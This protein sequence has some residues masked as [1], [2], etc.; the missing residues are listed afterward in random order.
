[1]RVLARKVEEYFLKLLESLKV[2]SQ[3]PT[4]LLKHAL[5]KRNQE[6]EEDNLVDLDDEENWRS[7][8]PRKFSELQD[9][10]FPLFLTFDGVRFF[11]SSRGGNPDVL[12]L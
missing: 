5:A 12:V 1:S 10:H 8:L 11:A 2:A 6:I 3:S 7:D 9:S 4:D